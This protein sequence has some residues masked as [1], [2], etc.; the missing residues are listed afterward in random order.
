MH[1]TSFSDNLRSVRDET[2]EVVMKHFFAEYPR[3][4]TSILAENSHPVIAVSDDTIV[5]CEE[6]LLGAFGDD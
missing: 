1:S 6:S 2:V 4:K 5:Q 3:L